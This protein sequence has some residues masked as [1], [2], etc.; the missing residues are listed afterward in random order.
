LCI[1]FLINN[2]INVLLIE[3]TFELLVF[4]EKIRVIFDSIIIVVLQCNFFLKEKKKR[5]RMRE[6][7]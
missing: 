6:E 3:V 4:S 2:I 5:G 1:A 7:Q